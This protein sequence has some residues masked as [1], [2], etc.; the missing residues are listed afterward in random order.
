M[1]YLILLNLYVKWS[2]TRENGLQL[3]RH[4]VSCDML[5]TFGSFVGYIKYKL[6]KQ[7]KIDR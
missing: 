2:E 7:S 3:T 5:A 1:P 4:I 6:K